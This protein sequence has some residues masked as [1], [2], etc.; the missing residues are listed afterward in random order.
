MFGEVVSGFEQNAAGGYEM[1]ERFSK[2]VNVPEMM[3]RVRSFMDVL[4]SEQLGDLVKRPA[5]KGGLPENVIAE[6]S[7]DL[8][9]YM[10]VTL[11][12][13]IEKSRR[14]KPSKEQPGNPDPII[15]IIT[16]GACPRS[17]CALLTRRFRTIRIRS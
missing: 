11:Q 1:V 16:D 5:L 15:N 14:W 12:E 9:D 2:F 3:K 7:D 6:A 17:I 13:R 4:T 10:K 8:S